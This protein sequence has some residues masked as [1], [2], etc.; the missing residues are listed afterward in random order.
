MV[1]KEILNRA[2]YLV[3]VIG[4]LCACTAQQTEGSPQPV[5]PKKVS[6]LTQLTPIPNTG[7]SNPSE[8]LETA[9]GQTVYVPA[10]SH[11]YYQDG[12]EFLLAT[13]LSIRNTSF[14]NPISVRSVRY[15]N[16]KG[17]L[18]K[19][20]SQKSLSIPPMATTEFFVEERDTSGGSGANFIVEWTA[21]KDVTEP[22]VEAVMIS[23][24]S[25]QGISLI[26]PGRVIKETSK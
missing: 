13:T 18:V 5:K 4:L 7:V 15:Y 1:G 25:Q 2:I 26:S 12:R 8:S 16:S 21:P 3:V 19:E 14:T 9:V 22:V 6:P 10:Y 11:V 17:H 20:Y 23:T 24:S